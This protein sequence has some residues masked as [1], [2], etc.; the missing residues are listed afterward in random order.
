[1]R[2]IANDAGHIDRCNFCHGL[3]SFIVHRHEMWTFCSPWPEPHTDNNFPIMKTNYSQK[4]LDVVSLSE[5]GQTGHNPKF[6]CPWPVWQLWVTIWLGLS[7]CCARFVNGVDGNII[8][9]Y[10]LTA[11]FISVSPITGWL[12]VLSPIFVTHTTNCGVIS[13]KKLFISWKNS[14][15]LLWCYFR[16]LHNE[17]AIVVKSG[18]Q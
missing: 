13:I 17:F 1:M 8:V 9:H 18:T 15:L 7:T 2:H 10:C 16:N 11:L 14:N 12:K 6:A 4:L 5:Y 3:R